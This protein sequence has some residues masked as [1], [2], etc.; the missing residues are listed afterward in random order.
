MAA[1]FKFQPIKG[2]SLN[3]FTV[4]IF[5]FWSS[6]SVDFFFPTGFSFSYWDMSISDLRVTGQLMHGALHRV[7]DGK[8]RR[9]RASFP[10]ERPWQVTAPLAG[11]KRLRK[12][13]KPQLKRDWKLPPQSLWPSYLIICRYS[14]PPLCEP[15]DSDIL[16]GFL[17]QL[18]KY[19]H[20]K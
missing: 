4:H 1:L 20:I 18:L 5:M 19:L 9:L 10:I 12:L 14:L 17:N 13:Q 7:T 15:G 2:Y 11:T 6:F 8:V 16:L 3:H